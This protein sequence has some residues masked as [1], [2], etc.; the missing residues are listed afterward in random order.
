MHVQVWMQ[1]VQCKINNLMKEK[2]CYLR[3]LYPLWLFNSLDLFGS[4]LLF[5][6]CPIPFLLPCFSWSLSLSWSFLLLLYTSISVTLLSVEI[7][8]FYWDSYCVFIIIYL[9][10]LGVYITMNIYLK[11]PGMP[12]SKLRYRL[13]INTKYIPIYLY[14]TDCTPPRVFH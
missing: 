2:D 6:Y 10:L 3:N 9:S 12:Q 13:T 14:S 1:N 8:G 11:R 7:W 4:L 5:S